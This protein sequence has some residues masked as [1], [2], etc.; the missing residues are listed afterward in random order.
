L[1][2]FHEDVTHIQPR[3][4]TNHDVDTGVNVL[5]ESATCTGVLI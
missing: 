5:Y 2:H 1:S 3:G 4:V